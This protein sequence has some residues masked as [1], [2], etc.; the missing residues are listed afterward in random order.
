M[1]DTLVSTGENLA[2]KD[3]READEEIS[4]GNSAQD[5]ETVPNIQ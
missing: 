3:K 1:P 4:G 2:C 5:W